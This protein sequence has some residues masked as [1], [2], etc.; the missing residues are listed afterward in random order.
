MFPPLYKNVVRGS[1]KYQDKNLSPTTNYN[2]EYL[3]LTVDY[4]CLINYVS[5]GL[6]PL[7]LASLDGLRGVEGPGLSPLPVG[8]VEIPLLSLLLPVHFSRLL[9]L[10]HHQLGHGTPLAPPLLPGQHGDQQQQQ[11]EQKCCQQ[12]LVGGE[13]DRELCTRLGSEGVVEGAGGWGKGT[14]PA[15]SAEGGV[16]VDLRTRGRGGAEQGEMPVGT[17]SPA[18]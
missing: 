13:G 2:I 5:P 4:K 12:P 9:P 11:G 14:L 17:G 7:G 3:Q 6:S 1:G 10:H 15:A 18:P 8:D 16:P